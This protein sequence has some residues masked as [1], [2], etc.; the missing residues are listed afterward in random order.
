MKNLFT[1]ME[2]NNKRHAGHLLALVAT[3]AVGDLTLQMDDCAMTEQ[4]E[5]I[6]F[7][8]SSWIA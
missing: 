7:N 8:N 5:A 2:C 1:L 6:T 3:Q 4:D